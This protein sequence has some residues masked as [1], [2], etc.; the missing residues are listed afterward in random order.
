[1]LQNVPR[2][3]DQT[4]T[5]RKSR[6]R[7]SHLTHKK[8]GG[9]YVH[10][11]IGRLAFGNSK[12][13]FPS[14]TARGHLLCPCLGARIVFCP[15]HCV[16]RPNQPT[17]LYAYARAFAPA[18]APTTRGAENA[19]A[20]RDM[21][22]QALSPRARS[23]RVVRQ[24]GRAR[25]ARPPPRLHLPSPLDPP[26]P[27]ASQV[28]PRSRLSSFLASP[29]LPPLL[30]IFSLLSPSSPL[31]DADATPLLSSRRTP[32]R[33]R[34]RIRF[35]QADWFLSQRRW[36]GGG[37]RGV[38]G[39]GAW[40]WA[41]EDVRGEGPA[42]C[43]AR[44]RAGNLLA[45]A[46]RTRVAVMRGR[47]ANAGCASRIGGRGLLAAGYARLR[48]PM[49]VFPGVI[50]SGGRGCALTRDALC[51]RSARARTRTQADSLSFPAPGDVDDDENGLVSVLGRGRM[52][53][54]V[55]GGCRR[56]RKRGAWE[57]TSMEVTM[58]GDSRIRVKKDEE[59]RIGH[60][61]KISRDEQTRNFGEEGRRGTGE[62]VGPKENAWM[63]KQGAVKATGPSIA[64][65]RERGEGEKDRR[66]LRLHSDS[67]VRE[68]GRWTQ[69]GGLSLDQ[70]E[71]RKY[72]VRGGKMKKEEERPE[73]QY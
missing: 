4:T 3:I 53:S 61:E 47:S 64:G 71:D 58:R 42:R 33:I 57:R 35:Q 37:R 40:S 68:G 9:A 17:V 72:G 6:S 36:A 12:A 73:R 67:G 66:H 24:I 49:C 10:K 21:E 30:L 60:P 69:V 43:G 19:D 45:G 65:E 32:A 5:R 18:P 52:R 54:K 41:A 29:S 46:A 31:S 55:R 51:V 25:A 14:I 11:Y 39:R 38:C 50:L 59:M 62:M 20:L 28:R 1:M 22:I 16:P 63:K 8:G 56:N 7:V 15:V 2:A 70:L 23:A 13:H 44:V 48:V 34:I 26:R 27:L